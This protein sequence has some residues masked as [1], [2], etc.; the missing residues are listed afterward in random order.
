MSNIGKNITKLRKEKGITQEQL[1][2]RL[3]VTRQAVSH[4]E[5]GKTHP[6][7]DILTALAEYFEI[8]IE[9]LIYGEKREDSK[10]IIGKRSAAISIDVGSAVGA[11]LAVV[12]S[13]SKWQSIGWAI[14]HGFFNWAY[15]IYYA[16]KY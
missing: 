1:A 16:I 10:I 11:A 4:W 8:S 7:I 6:D 3:H 2:E 14:I 12:L 5:N 15:V 9:E 13:Y